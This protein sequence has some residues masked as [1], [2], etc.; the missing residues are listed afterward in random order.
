MNEKAISSACADIFR[1]SLTEDEKSPVTIAKYGRDVQAFLA[2]AAGAEVTKET[3]IRYKQHLQEHYAPASVNSMLAALNRFFKTIGRHDCVVKSLKIQRQAFRGR[4]RELSR[5]EYFRLLDAARRKN[6]V[7]LCMLMQTLAATGIRV[8]ELRFITVEAA[9][10]SRATVSLKGKTR[11]VLLPKPLCREL[12]RYAGAR[13]ICSGSIFV[14][15]SGKPMD[16]SNILHSMK[17]LCGAARVARENQ[18]LQKRLR[19][20]LE[21]YT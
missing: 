9:R 10:Q 1:R 18:A 12:L 11:Q 6:D 21:S 8:S 14:T 16:R 13:G 19:Q 20:D 5:A 17:A 4:E 15:R 2:F 7:R 3:V